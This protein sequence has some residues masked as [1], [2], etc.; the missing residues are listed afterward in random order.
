MSEP[1]TLSLFAGYGI[2]IEFM[3]VDRQ[4]LAV[5]PLVDVLFESVNG[6]RGSDVED[7]PLWWSNE[8]VAHVLELKTA[9]P[10]G[11]IVLPLA[12]FESTVQRVN[13]RLAEW[14]AMLLP[15]GMH[16]FMNPHTETKLWP[17]ENCDIYAAFDRV[18][19]CRGHG[20]SNLQS[21]HLNL[22]FANAEEFRSL[23]AAIRLL[24]PILPWIAASSP[25]VDG[26]T[27]G[28]D[29][30]RMHFYRGNS[31]AI[32][33]ISGDVVPEPIASPDEYQSQI[34]GRLYADIA[35]HDPDGILQEEWLNARGAIARFYRNTIEIRV[36]DAQECP[37]MDLAIV[38]MVVALLK[39]LT[40]ERWST[41]DAQF[42]YPQENLVA[43]FDAALDPNKPV[44]A[45]VLASYGLLLGLEL[46]PGDD[47]GSLWQRLLTRLAE[48]DELA[49]VWREPAAFLAREG[50][51][52]SRIRRALGPR[53]HHD[54]LLSV[55]HQLAHCL[56]QGQPFVP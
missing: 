41:T 14:D 24:L 48:G 8:L 37:R 17:E 56:D 23:H 46:S 21:T 36:L 29:G 44:H 40:G 12:A 26:V 19:N 16:P 49:A 52:G 7:G 33:S 42:H 43:L 15:G 34:L 55:Y 22:P 11:D 35:P 13:H 51:L 18:F 1:A 28:R 4:S 45:E 20:W 10:V 25:V 39:E 6:Y 50:S 3:V 53:F 31:R 9:A 2:E 38:A 32:P 47:I 30:N 54:K 27:N 5:R